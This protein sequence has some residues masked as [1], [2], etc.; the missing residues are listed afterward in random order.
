MR[1]MAAAQGDIEADTARF[2]EVVAEADRQMDEIAQSVENGGRAFGQNK[3]DIAAL[4][5]T[6]EE[7]G[8]AIK[9]NR[10]TLTD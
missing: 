10:K 8:A 2:A 9:S 1:D 5:K 6:Y 4:N 3:K 7:L